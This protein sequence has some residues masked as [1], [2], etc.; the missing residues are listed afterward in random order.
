MFIIILAGTLSANFISA[1]EKIDV[2]SASLENLVKIIHI[3]EARAK[4]LISL[5]PFSSLDDLDRI[6]GIGTSRIADI[7]KQGLSWVSN[8]REA[9]PGPGKEKELTAAVAEQ[10]PQKSSL[11]PLIPIMAA[12]FSATIILLLKNKVKVG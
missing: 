11:P 8:P 9:Q 7:K 1:A 10:I 12:A 4:E 2:N 3:G 5:R 6:K